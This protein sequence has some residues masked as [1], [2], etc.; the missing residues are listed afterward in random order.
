VLTG[1]GEN[2]KIGVLMFPNPATRVFNIKSDHEILSVELISLMGQ[3]ISL[4][5]VNA[6]NHQINVSDLPTGVYIIKV[7]TGNGAVTERI[8]I[9]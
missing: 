5:Q 6:D 1:I 9:E 8:S 3:R 7:E 2:E 4:E